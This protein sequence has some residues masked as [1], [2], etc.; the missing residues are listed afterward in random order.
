MALMVLT[1]ANAGSIH[2]MEQAINRIS[3]LLQQANIVRSESTLPIKVGAVLVRGRRIIKEACNTDGSFRFL[4]IWSRH[5]EVNATLNINA[6]GTTIYIYR[7]HGTYYSPMLACPCNYCRE[8]LHFV[9][10]KEAIY[11]IPEYP[12]YQRIDI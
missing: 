2:E 7:S 10:V 1:A 8:W 4:P 12:F 5:A 11:T 9:G 6:T 3:R